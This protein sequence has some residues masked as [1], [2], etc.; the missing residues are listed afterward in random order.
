MVEHPTDSKVQ[1]IEGRSN[2]PAAVDGVPVTRHIA[3]RQYQAT[4][5]GIEGRTIS[6]TGG[7]G[8]SLLAMH[9]VAEPQR[10]IPPFPWHSGTLKA[11]TSSEGIATT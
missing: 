3:S 7:R 9:I 1:V 10:A 2:I 6:K 5:G 4:C 11:P 8:I